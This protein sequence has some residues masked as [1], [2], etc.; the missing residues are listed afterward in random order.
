LDVEAGDLLPSPEMKAFLLVGI[1]G[2]LGSAGRYLVGLLVPTSVSGLPLPTLVVNVVGS[3][4]IGFLAAF[5]EARLGR[6]LWLLAVVGGLGGFTTFSAFSAE[7]TALLQAG[8]GG[9]ALLNIGSQVVLGLLA[10]WLGLS[11]GQRYL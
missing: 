2:F 6:D 3:L 8:R 1:G 7:T 4:L 10:A 9:V 5:G 11:V